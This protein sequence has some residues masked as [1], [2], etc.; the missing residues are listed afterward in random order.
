VSAIDCDPLRL[1][2]DEAS[3][4]GKARHSAHRM[5]QHRM[6]QHRMAALQRAAL[7][8]RGGVRA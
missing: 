6:A 3:D 5:E 7:T 1:V 8:R 4:R 2:A